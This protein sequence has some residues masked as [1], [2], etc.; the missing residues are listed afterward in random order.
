MKAGTAVER[1]VLVL[2]SQG[3]ETPAEVRM[4]IRH[5]AIDRDGLTSKIALFAA[6]LGFLG[7]GDQRPLNAIAVGLQEDHTVLRELSDC[8]KEQRSDRGGATQTNG[9]IG[10]VESPHNFN[11]LVG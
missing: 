3:L 1:R 11:K 9:S 10:L 6:R 7:C 4:R 8:S 5:S 2:R